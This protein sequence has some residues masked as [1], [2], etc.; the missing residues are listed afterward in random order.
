MRY[1]GVLLLLAMLISGIAPLTYASA[2]PASATRRPLSI[3]QGPDHA[4]WFTELDGNRIGRITTDGHATEYSLPTPHSGPAGIT[5]GPDGALWFTELYADA[6]GRLDPRTGSLREYPVPRRDFAPYQ[7]TTGSDGAL[8]FTGF[9]VTGIDR[10][11]PHTGQFGV[12]YPIAGTN[13]MGI[14]RG[15]DGALW[16]AT[17]HARTVARLSAAGTLR[18]FT[19]P[20]SVAGEP[21][22]ITSGPDHA[23]WFTETNA[24]QIG[25]LAL[26]GALSTFPT[27]QNGWAIAPGPDGNLWFAE[28]FAIGR[29]TPAGSVQEFP[30]DVEQDSP[31]FGIAA[32]PDHALWFTEPGGDRIGRV[33]LHGAITRFSLAGAA[34]HAAAPAPRIVPP[35]RAVTPSAAAPTDIAS[36][37]DGSEWFTEINSNRLGHILPDGTLHFTS[38][39]ASRSGPAGITVA[40]DGTVWFTEFYGNAVGRLDPATGA[41]HLYALSTPNSKPRGIMLASDGSVWITEYGSDRLGQLDLKIGAIFELDLPAGS[42]PWALARAPGGGLWFTERDANAIG[43]IDANDTITRYA[44]APPSGAPNRTAQPLGLTSEPDGTIWFAE[45]GF[46]SIGRREPDGKFSIF[47]PTDDSEGYPVDV[48]TAPDGKIWY[49]TD[50]DAVGRLFDKP[51]PLR[52]PAAPLSFLRLSY[53][54]DQDQMSELAF[55]ADGTL[56]VAGSQTQTIDALRA[57]GTVRRIPLPGHSS[58]PILVVASGATLWIAEPG[59]NAIARRAPDGVITDFPIPSANAQPS[60]I[61]P[62]PDGSVY[63]TEQETGKIGRIDPAGHIQEFA[64]ADPRAAPASIAIVPD[65]STGRYLV[66]VAERSA[67]SLGVLDP[68]TGTIQEHP[69][70]ETV[71]CPDTLTT[72]SSGTLYLGYCFSPSLAQITSNGT[73]NPVPNIQLDSYGLIRPGPNGDVLVAG[74]PQQNELERVAPDG[75][76]TLYLLPDTRGDTVDAVTAPD[77][78]IWFTDQEVNRVGVLDPRT[79]KVQEFTVPTPLSSPSGIT[80]DSRGTVWFTERDADAVASVSPSG[81]IHEYPV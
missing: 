46:G 81:T 9:T 24:H 44:I 63:F 21:F 69:L 59:R 20:G 10:L 30:L 48:T 49:V 27:H 12:Y 47:Y 71:S 58:A 3:V 37:P 31:A 13:V 33:D 29:V 38:L 6:I 39:P 19:R 72:T 22:G 36:A 28:D 57:D 40:A 67:N 64:L 55:S 50:E 43:H 79:R 11:D 5:L 17:G 75:S 74:E 66:W 18:S 42:G 25:R 32:G 76:Q 7:I 52:F 78:R 8:W 51:S 70:P 1:C 61:A 23:L 45:S 53:S 15:P 65:A 54:T 2:Q 41:I 16:L 35:G 77:G 56:W 68:Q 60:G 34:V 73:I 62:A 26:D 80:V 4:L 14:A